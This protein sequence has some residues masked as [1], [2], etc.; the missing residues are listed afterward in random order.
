MGGTGAGS[1]DLFYLGQHENSGNPEAHF[2]GTGHE[3][4][5]QSG[6]LITGF[7]AGIGAGGT[8]LGVSRFLQKVRSEIVLAGAV[9]VGIS[10]ILRLRPLDPDNV[11]HHRNLDVQEVYTVDHDRALWWQERVS[12]AIGFPVGPSSG[13]A[14]EAA[15]YMIAGFMNKVQYSASKA[16]AEV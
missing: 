2:T 12:R 10:G 8:L 7:A 6:G 11:A 14:M 13:A 4:W 3:I 15:A 1:D 9:P 16:P 5:A